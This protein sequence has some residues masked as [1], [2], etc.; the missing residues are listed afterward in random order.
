MAHRV[1]STVFFLFLIRGLIKIRWRMLRCYA[2][3]QS[4]LCIPSVPIVAV[5][6]RLLLSQHTPTYCLTTCIMTHCFDVI[7]LC[8]ARYIHEMKLHCKLYINGRR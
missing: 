2:I 1:L 8:T 4:L 7:D 6:Y 3:I 5:I